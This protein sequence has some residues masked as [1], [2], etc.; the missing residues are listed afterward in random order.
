MTI[1]HKRKKELSES[2]RIHAEPGESYSKFVKRARKI[3][4]YTGT[5]II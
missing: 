4:R 2:Y 1:S 5:K 3:K